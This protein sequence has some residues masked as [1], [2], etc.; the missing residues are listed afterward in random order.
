MD[1]LDFNRCSL[2]KCKCGWNVIFGSGSEEELEELKKAIFRMPLKRLRD[3]T[4]YK[5]K[6]N[7]ERFL[8]K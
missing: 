6:I 3:K 5:E 7:Q 1:I 8:D 4:N 2:P